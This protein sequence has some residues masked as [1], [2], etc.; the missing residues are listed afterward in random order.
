MVPLSERI[1]GETGA[2]V[3]PFLL[4]YFCIFYLHIFLSERDIIVLP[5]HLATNWHNYFCKK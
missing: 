3:P 5:E 4:I 2:C 1:V